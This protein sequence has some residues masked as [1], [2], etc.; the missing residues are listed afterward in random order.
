MEPSNRTRVCSIVFVDIVKYSAQHVAEQIVVKEHFNNVLRDA[1]ENVA[2]N[3]RIILDTGDGAAICFLGDPEEAFFAAWSV[4][5]AVLETGTTCK[6][7][8]HVRI[9]INL[10]P[11][12]VVKD[13][14]GNLNVLG[15]GIN[16]AQRVM[17]IAATN[18]VLVS[19]SFYEVV[20][21][22]SSEYA[23]ML[24]YVGTHKDKHVREHTVFEVVPLGTRLT[25]APAAVPETSESQFSA[26]NAPQGDPAPRADPAAAAQAPQPGLAVNPDTFLEL[27][28]SLAHE[29]G[30]IAKALMKKVAAKASSLK[31]LKELLAA[32]IRSDKSRMSF[33]D[34]VRKIH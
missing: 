9:G 23:G 1:I 11:V 22:L 32:E 13:I 5:N 29:L 7:P 26:T 21:K 27:E 10:G 24:Q 14:N 20:S 30:P 25:A 6:V 18:Q 31:E 2:A 33:V 8:Y 4:R 3:E 34:A 15:D 28:R 16:D 19:R 17:A 12:R